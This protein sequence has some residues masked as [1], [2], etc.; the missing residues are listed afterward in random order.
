M[1]ASRI[2]ICDDHEIVREALRARLDAVP[3]FEVVGEAADGRKVIDVVRRTRPDLVVIDVELPG[4]DG[5]SASVRMLELW[6]DQK[7]LVFTAHDQ[8]SVC[9]LVAQAGGQGCVSKSASTSEI[10]RACRAVLGGGTWFETVSGQV[11]G[12]GDELRRLRSLSDRELEILNLLAGGMRASDIAE[13]TGL[14]KATVYTHV[15]NVVNKLGVQT[16]TQA[17]AM[18]IQY[19]FLNPSDAPVRPVKPAR[20]TPANSR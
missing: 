16:R 8:A 18:A 10:E 7:I 12:E 6:P 5:I 13:A 17:A 20:G 2:V 15:R 9:D 19:S 1:A 14:Q 4:S 3:D 11:D